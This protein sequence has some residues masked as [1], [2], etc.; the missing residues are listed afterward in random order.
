[1]RATLYDVHDKTQHQNLLLPDFPPAAAT[2]FAIEDFRA[3]ARQK[4]QEP[5]GKPWCSNGQPLRQKQED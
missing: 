1:M 5:K 4:G 3:G 2:C